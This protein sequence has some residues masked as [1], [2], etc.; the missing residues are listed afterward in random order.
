MKKLVFK[1]IKNTGATERLCVKQGADLTCL[2]TTNCARCQGVISKSGGGSW[3]GDC[4]L[5]GCFS[6]R[7]SK[8]CKKR[9]HAKAI[10]DFARL[11]LYF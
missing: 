10:I 11:M 7:F 9:L 5:Y 3:T 1:W 2:F 6:V 8:T 4:F